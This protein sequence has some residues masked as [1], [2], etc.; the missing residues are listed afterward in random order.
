MCAANAFVTPRVRRK[1][2]ISS[3]NQQRAGRAGRAGRETAN[4][5][6]AREG[7]RSKKGAS[8]DDGRLLSSFLSSHAHM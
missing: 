5:N 4:E 1:E 7:R 2:K 6:I 3:N 8:G